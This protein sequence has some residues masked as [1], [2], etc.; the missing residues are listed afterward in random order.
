MEHPPL[1]AKQIIGLHR[2]FI[3]APESCFRLP[4]LALLAGNV[5]TYLAAV[6]P[7]I[8]TSYWDRRPQ[9]TPGRLRRLLAR[10]DFPNLAHWP[11]QLRKSARFPPIC[12]KVSRD[13]D[14]KTL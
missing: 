9:A 11:P 3:F 4:E 8:P 12:P 5:L 1:A 14:G 2:Q 10:A 7:P 6:L 13:I